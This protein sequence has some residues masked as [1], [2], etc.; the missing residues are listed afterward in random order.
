MFVSQMAAMEVYARHMYRAFTQSEVSIRFVDTSSFSVSSSSS[1][2]SSPQGY[3]L[4][5]LWMDS[6]ASDESSSSAPKVHSVDAV[7]DEEQH[8]QVG[9]LQT[10]SGL[11]RRSSTAMNRGDSS[12]HLGLVCFISSPLN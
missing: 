10:A 7:A 5:S 1:S 12:A 2:S 6:D 4:A 11:H 8:D 9:A 3:L